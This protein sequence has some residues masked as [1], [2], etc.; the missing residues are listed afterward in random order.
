MLTGAG[1]RIKTLLVLLGAT[2]L[3]AYYAGRQSNAVAQPPPA[4]TKAVVSR[5]SHHPPLPR[6]RPQMRADP[7]PVSIV[8]TRD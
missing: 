4:A 8:R 1:M 2:A 3:V 6:P 7:L 5:P